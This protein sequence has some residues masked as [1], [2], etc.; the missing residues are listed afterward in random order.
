MKTRQ[1][2]SKTLAMCLAL[3][4][5]VSVFGACNDSDTVAIPV[6]LPE[7]ADDREIDLLGY[8]NPT[9]G[10]YTFDGATM[11]SGTDY[12]TVE[13]FKEYMDAGMNIALARYDSQLDKEVTAETWP[14]SGTKIFCDKAYE[15]GLK[16]IIIS[17]AYFTNIIG[18]TN[19]PI[20]GD[21]FPTQEAL[22]E[23][24]ANRLAIYKDTPGFYGV[25]LTDEPRYYLLEN[26]GI[27]HRAIKTVMPECYIYNNLHYLHAG[28]RD[29]DIYIDVDA[30]KAAHPGET[31][32]SKEAY[33]TYLRNFFEYS[34]AEN[35]AVDVY[36][37]KEDAEEFVSTFF[38]N[39]QIL[40]GLCDEYNAELSFTMQSITYISN[41]VY[42]N[43]IMSK[44]DLWKQMNT[45]LGYGAT[46]LQ[47]YTYFPYPSYSPTGTSIGNFIDREGNKTSVYYNAQAVNRAVR[48]FDHVLLHYEFQGA[49]FYLNNPLASSS[50]E[51]YLSKDSTPFDN[52]F[53]HKLL[54]GLT[55]NNDALL[56]T[57]L[58]DEKNGL[59]MYMI[60]NALDVLYSSTGIMDYTDCTFTAEFPGYDYVAEYDCGE[61]RYV[62]LDN[63]K[64]TNT[65]SSGYAVFLIPLK[66]S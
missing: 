65:L 25:A 66:V 41:G 59:Y 17:D 40:R 5:S 28:E 51:K 21:Y 63:G 7:Y 16:K 62:K 11:D 61:L 42:T 34:G 27:V 47:Y 32:T 3:I 36:P 31:L 45:M 39:I 57:E 55:Q 9:D 52:T 58:K 8:V 20:V 48:K 1:W 56:T 30:W 29:Q 18:Y 19:G 23:A 22:E 53:E 10:T 49:K 46:S 4:A 2:L 60:M 6:S 35:L 43:R 26:Y 15:A 64:Y 37:F 50:A 54:K 24:I 38:T 12:R 13:R 33:T 44:N 14:V